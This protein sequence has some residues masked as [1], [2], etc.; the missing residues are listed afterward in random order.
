M[1]NVTEVYEKTVEIISALYPD[2]KR[3][4]YPYSLQD[5]KSI[6]LRDGWGIKVGSSSYEELEW[7]S[8]VN[9][10]NIS[11][12]FTRENFRNDSD[13]GK[14]DDLAL[15]LMEDV[16]TLQKRLFSP[17]NLTIPDNLMKVDISDVST[18]ETIAGD[19]TSFLSMEA[20][21]IF[22]IKEAI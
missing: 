7:C 19:K 9:A 21:F 18:I 2:K 15:Y 3:I 8:F 5:N 17:D 16:Y 20:N 14:I 22:H 11:V 1:S 6:H 10:R 4:P 12:V 13:A